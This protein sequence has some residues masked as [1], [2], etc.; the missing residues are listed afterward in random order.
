MCV[1]DLVQGKVFQPHTGMKKL[2]LMATDDPSFSR[3]QVE[4]RT[5]FMPRKL[6]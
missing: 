6:T 1:S 3:V 2:R 5:N 4:S